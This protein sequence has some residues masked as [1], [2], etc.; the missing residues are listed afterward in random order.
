MVI[1]FLINKLEMS[2]L[3]LTGASH[4]CFVEEAPIGARVLIFL[5]NDLGLP[6]IKAKGSRFFFS[7]LPTSIQYD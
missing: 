2:S 3:V 4:E 6:D 1:R 7:R 5:V